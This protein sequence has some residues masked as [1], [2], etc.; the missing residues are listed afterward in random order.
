MNATSHFVLVEVVDGHL[1]VVIL[2]SFEELFVERFELAHW[3]INLVEIELECF[4][5][6]NVIELRIETHNI[7]PWL[8]SYRITKHVRLNLIIKDESLVKTDLKSTNYC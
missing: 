2:T 4:L 1:V 7:N 5:F 3:V 8:L 6:H